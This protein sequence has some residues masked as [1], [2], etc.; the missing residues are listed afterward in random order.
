M[1]KL[2]EVVMLAAL[3]CSIVACGQ[4][5]NS[6]HSMET[7]QTYSLC[8]KTED[9]RQRLYDQAKDFA[10]QQKAQFIDRG[11]GVQ[12]E[13]TSLKSNVLNATDGNPIL[14]TIE[15]PDVLR[16]SITNLGLKEKIALAVSFSD[17]AVEDGPIAGFM[18][19]LNRFW[20]IQKVGE[21]V[22]NDPPCSPLDVPPSSGA[23]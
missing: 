19:D 8:P 12:K 3:L 15:K 13:L 17:T 14:L 9:S 6:A 18:G 2:R 11:P 21:S 1:W 16:I 5:S 23:G 4:A 10:G 20:T 22:T 7:K